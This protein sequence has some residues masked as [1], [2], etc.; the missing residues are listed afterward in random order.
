MRLCLNKADTHTKLHLRTVFVWFYD[1]RQSDRGTMMIKSRITCIFLALI[2]LVSL[3]GCAS[4]QSLLGTK[5]TLTIILNSN[6][7]NSGSGDVNI[8]FGPHVYNRNEVV[9]ITATPKPGS[10]PLGQAPCQKVY[11]WS[12]AG[13]D[14]SG[15]AIR[16]GMGGCRKRCGSE[17]DLAKSAWVSPSDGEGCHFGFFN[18]R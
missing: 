1:S 11:R 12:P 10:A 17:L 6:Q 18:F 3:T 14:G 15:N 13:Q 9:A 16:T 7:G 4:V 5:C 8:G 2:L